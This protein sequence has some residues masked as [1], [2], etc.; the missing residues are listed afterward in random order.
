MR[1]SVVISTFNRR[2]QLINA[3][4]ALEFQTFEDFEVI[5]VNGPSTD[6]TADVVASRWPSARLIAFNE[7]NLSK[8][9]NL[10]IA[11]S[12]AEI[13]AFV[14][15]DGVASATWLEELVAAYDGPEIGGA[16]GIVVDANGVDLQYR[17][18]LCTRLCV[19]QFFLEELL[20]E[21]LAAAMLP[22]ADPFVYLQGTN[23]SF[24]RDALSKIGGFNEQIEY[25]GD[26]SD[27]CL[28]LIDAGY[29][30]VPL[31]SASVMHKYA[32]SH[33]R[34][35]TGFVFDPYTTLKNHHLFALTNGATARDLRFIYRNLECYVEN[36]REGARWH[37][38]R[39][40]ITR[41]ELDRF[42]MRLQEGVRAGL[43][44]ARKPRQSRHFD[45]PKAALFEPFATRPAAPAGRRHVALLCPEVFVRPPVGTQADVYS[46]AAGLSDEGVIVH[47]A[48][49]GQERELV[50]FDD[51]GFYIHYVCYTGDQKLASRLDGYA[52][53]KFDVM[54]ARHFAR[55]SAPFNIAAVLRFEEASC[56]SFLAELLNRPEI[57]V[58]PARIDRRSSPLGDRSEEIRALI[59]KIDSAV[60]DP[61]VFSREKLNDLIERT[62]RASD[63]ARRGCGIAVL[64]DLLDEARPEPTKFL[65]IRRAF[66]LSD[67]DFIRRVYEI[68]LDRRLAE[69]EF[70]RTAT[71]IILVQG[72]RVDFLRMMVASEEFESTSDSRIVRENFGDFAERLGRLPDST[73]LA[74]SRR[75]AEIYDAL[76][77]S[78][79]RDSDRQYVAICYRLVLGREPDDLALAVGPAAMIREWEGR[80]GFVR[81]MIWCPEL[82]GQALAGS[83]QSGFHAFEQRARKLLDPSLGRESLSDTELYEEL[84][85]SEANDADVDYVE[86]LYRELYARAVDDAVKALGCSA[87]IADA[88][89]RKDLAL[90]MLSSPEGRSSLRSRRLALIA[91]AAEPAREANTALA[92][93]EM[94]LAEKIDGKE[95]VS[96]S[97]GGG[98]G[99]VLMCTPFLREFKKRHPSVRLQF[100]TKYAPLV[101]GLP[102]L[103]YVG[104]TFYEPADAIPLLY[105]RDIPTRRH[106][107]QIFANNMGLALD[108]LRPSC[109]IDPHVFAT[110]GARL[111]PHMRPLIVIQR[112][113]SDWTPNKNWPSEYWTALIKRLTDIAFVIEIGGLSS[114]QERFRNYLDLQ[115]KTSL[116]E[117]AAVIKLADL[118]VGPIS[119][120]AHIAA[121]VGTPAVVIVGGYE[122]AENTAYPGNKMFS[123]EAPCAPCWLQT[124]CPRNLMCLQMITPEFVFA[125]VERALADQGLFPRGNIER[126]SARLAAE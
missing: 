82:T 123:T 56:A 70:D 8:S 62:I 61:Q 88:G 106:L 40:N 47:L 67:R 97:R 10:G 94:A 14:D 23:C 85:R 107:A 25:Y 115:G 1:V 119:G 99:D 11:A 7:R 21:R 120:P 38:K 28:R 24:R 52:S 100:F 12:S 74:A 50:E 116:Q 111:E 124:Q 53:V 121:A 103:D 34:N 26:E 112:Q 51:R 77:A 20:P 16:G 13:V 110:M 45:P 84:L 65:E 73:L 87:L 32:A 55:L 118:F 60:L 9:R 59:D 6:G 75:A 22:G 48:V 69:N 125:G 72:G 49:R 104:N 39:G 63:F 27:V 105:E 57:T 113:T 58:D 42:N 3:L 90:R 4:A 93:R 37:F 66:D 76:G 15:D 36:C 2:Q 44:A 109:A 98:L 68:L 122:L 78:L 96:F 86:R 102:F 114:A 29:K 18:S 126:R 5:V 81:Q 117:M 101:E 41:E 31:D 64:N 91:N 92:A 30:L 79:A 95:I 83:L 35:A 71:E 33:T 46:F 89:G 108:D 17:F 54:A 43:L 80:L 19:G